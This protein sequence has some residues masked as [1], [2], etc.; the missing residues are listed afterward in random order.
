M[1]F[2]AEQAL[3]RAILVFNHTHWNDLK[4]IK[5]LHLTTQNGNQQRS[6]LA[7]TDD[8]KWEEGKSAKVDYTSNA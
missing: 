1:L 4:L 7:E 8:V 3:A 6:S 2:F 5:Q